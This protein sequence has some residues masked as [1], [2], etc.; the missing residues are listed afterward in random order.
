M[1]HILGRSGR[2]ALARCAASRALLA[3]DFDGTL[4]PIVDQPWRARMRRSTRALLARLA[5]SY[6]CVIISGRA[7]ADVRRRV[8]GSGV[9]GVVGNHGL[10]PW[11]RARRLRSQVR[12]WRPL[13]RGAQEAAAGVRIEDK[14]LSLALHYRRSRDKRRARAWI[15]RAVAALRAARVIDGKMVVNVLPGGAPGK[16]AALRRERT[17]LRCERALY[18]GD[19]V[20]DEDAFAALRPARLTAVRVGK[21][22][23]SAAAFYVRDQREVDALLRALLR[24]RGLNAA[25]AA[26]RSGRRPSG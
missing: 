24:L 4:A 2:A 15:R 1:R 16:G 5:R 20:T 23:G 19:D 10:E 22:A 11:L 8:R 13:L 18:V 12:R 3:F 21:R 26:S 25:A 17:R 7:R 14:G 9:R 6:P